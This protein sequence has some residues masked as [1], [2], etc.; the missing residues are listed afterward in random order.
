MN[1]LLITLRIIHIFGGVFWAGASIFMAGMVE[2]AVRASAPESSR[3]MQALTTRTP[4]L[5][6]L[7]AAGWLTTLSGLWLYW[8]IFKGINVSYGYGLMLTVGGVAGLLGAAVGS[9]MQG[10]A[11]SKMIALGK[12]ITA[13]GGPPRPEQLAQMARLQQT[14]AT[15]GRITAILLTIAVLGMAAAQYVSF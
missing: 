4:F 11:S 6:A 7:A 8:L 3:F 1:I 14:L 12:Q 13:A 5:L 9:S 10:Q 15:G 2:P